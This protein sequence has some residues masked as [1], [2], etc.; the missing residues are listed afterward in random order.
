M[1][2]FIPNLTQV[3]WLG[4]SLLHGGLLVAAAILLL[5]ERSIGPLL[6]LIGGT[7]SLLLG[8]GVQSL[9]LF[10]KYEL[11]A[12]LGPVN[13]LGALL[14]AVGLLIYA[15]N[16]RGL[17]KRLAGPVDIVDQPRD[18]YQVNEKAGR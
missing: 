6:M 7:I 11:V 4:F 15:L 10:Q 16:R 13:G 17:T 12:F 2:S 5:K 3:F 18:Q 8:T 1:S 14:F 9:A